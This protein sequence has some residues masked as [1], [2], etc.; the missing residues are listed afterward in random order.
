MAPPRKQPSALK[1]ASGTYRPDRDP[2]PELEPRPVSLAA[3]PLPPNT[4]GAEGVK[5]WQANADVL[6]QIGLLTCGDLDS[7]ECYC[8]LWDE[9]AELEAAIAKDGRFITAMSGR[10]TSHPAATQLKAVRDEIRR[11]QQE[12]GMTPSGRCG[13]QVQKPEQK[14]VSRRKRG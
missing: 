14:K 4:L 8:K 7:F 10:K 12:F 11:Y 2:D 1:V 3:V 6:H 9:A 5:R 13:L